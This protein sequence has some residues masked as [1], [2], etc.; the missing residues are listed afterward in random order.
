M[1]LSRR[2]PAAARIVRA[3]RELTG[4]PAS[5]RPRRIGPGARTLV[6]C[7]GGADSSALL[8][9]LATASRDVVVAHVIH[10]LRPRA[11]TEA[12]RIAVRRLAQWLGLECDERW[13]SVPR[14]RGTGNPEALARRLRYAALEEMARAHGCRFVAT[15]HHADDQLETMLMGLIRGAGPRGLA[16]IAVRRPMTGPGGVQL[17]R[18]ML[19]D[20][21]GRVAPSTRA[22]AEAICRAAGWSWR[23]DLTNADATLL[24]N[25]IRR[26]VLPILESLRPGASRRAARSAAVL[27]FVAAMVSRR[28]AMVARQASREPVNGQAALV[29]RRAILRRQSPMVVGEV[30]RSSRRG[31]DRLGRRALAAAVQAIRDD[32]TEPRVLRVGGLEFHVR[33]DTVTVQAIGR[34]GMNPQ[35]A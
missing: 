17:I 15:A 29:W 22:D 1:P 19:G 11:E 6:A 35:P 10:D 31:S 23:T 4:D 7:S 18:P 26:N 27:G 2:Q 21:S 20:R 32:S 33:A 5:G 24:R 28:A 3:W 8:L 14:G 16:G 9:A 12:D 25:A 34:Q 30:L 13:I